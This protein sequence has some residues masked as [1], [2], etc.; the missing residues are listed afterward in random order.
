MRKLILKHHSQHS[1]KDYVPDGPFPKN[2]TRYLFEPLENTIRDQLIPALIGRE[3]CD[4]ERQLLALP[5]RH[6]GLGQTNPQ[7]NAKTEYN[8]SM[9][10][11]AK[12]T[13]QIYN[14]KLN[15]ECNSL[16]QWFPNLF[17]PLPKSR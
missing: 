2:S 17:K 3:V 4:A 7:T 13:D 15:F 11:T 10:I 16:D 14:Q 6:G 12:L 5:L 8:N 1:P 9:L